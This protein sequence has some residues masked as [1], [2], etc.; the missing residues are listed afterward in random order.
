VIYENLDQ[1]GWVVKEFHKGR[2]SPLQA[3]NEFQNLEKGRAIHADNVV[4]AQAPA[5]PRQGWIVKEQ[6]VPDTPMQADY[7]ALP[8]LEQDFINGGVQ[9]V[10]G[11]IMF[12]HTVDNFT[13]RWILIE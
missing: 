5:N 12:G 4:K 7:A 11:N 9:D 1:P 10:G 3:R 8:Q 6:V 2:M 13:P